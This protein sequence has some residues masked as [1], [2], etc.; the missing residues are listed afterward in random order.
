MPLDANTV[1]ALS[2]YAKT[3]REPEVAPDESSTEKPK[4]R[5]QPRVSIF[6]R[7]TR[8]AASQSSSDESME[9]LDMDSSDEEKPPRK[10]LAHERPVSLMPVKRVAGF[11]GHDMDEAKDKEGEANAKELPGRPPVALPTRRNLNGSKYRRRVANE[12]V[13]DDEF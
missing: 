11:D 2:T 1:R 8:G 6:G 3:L 9:D 13:E 4:P 10:P 12:D 7:P 5:L